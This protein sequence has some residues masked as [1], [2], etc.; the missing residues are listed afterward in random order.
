M[1]NKKDSLK[2]NANFDKNYQIRNQPGMFEEMYQNNVGDY[3]P[4]ESLMENILLEDQFKKLSQISEKS[5]TSHKP[6]EKNPQNFSKK[7]I[8]KPFNTLNSPKSNNWSVSQHP[9]YCYAN[10]NKISSNLTYFYG[11]FQK[12]DSPK[13]TFQGRE[14]P[15][16]HRD[17]DQPANL[18]DPFSLRCMMASPKPIEEIAQRNPG[19]YKT[20]YFGSG[21]SQRAEENRRIQMLQKYDHII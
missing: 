21:H 3:K 19:Y 8:Y 9:L 11:S 7:T 10:S 6:I 4:Q 18:N 5:S 12:F 14:N 17:L 15:S 20:S 1:T 13:F 16:I 2:I